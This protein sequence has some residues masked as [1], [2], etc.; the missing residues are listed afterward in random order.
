MASKQK[1]DKTK[2]QPIEYKVLVGEV[3]D[4]LKASYLAKKKTWGF[5]ING[6]HMRIIIAVN[7]THLVKKMILAR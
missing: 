3:E 1:I 2:E 7:R 5:M 6:A 4:Q